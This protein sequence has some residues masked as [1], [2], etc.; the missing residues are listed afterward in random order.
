MFRAT[1]V[2][3]ICLLGAAGFYV[4]N[5]S[6]AFRDPVR[7]P[8]AVAERTEQNFG[9]VT[10]GDG[11]EATFLVRNKGARRLILA[12]QSECC[13]SANQEIIVPPGKSQ[14]LTF[15]I[16]TNQR[17]LG[18]HCEVVYYETNDRLHPTLAFTMV[19]DLT[20]DGHQLE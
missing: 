5:V 10:A 17:H 7:E 4:S 16:P 14:E 9:Q 1:I 20:S 3:A 2:A 19:F 18:P 8:L 13:G 6:E 11:L 12:E 15:R